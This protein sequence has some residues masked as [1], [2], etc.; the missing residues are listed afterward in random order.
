MI[1]LESLPSGMAMLR[2]VSVSS[3][4]AYS[5][6]GGGFRSFAPDTASYGGG[7]SR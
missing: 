3:F 7:M 2:D 4:C 1:A 5:L 6:Y